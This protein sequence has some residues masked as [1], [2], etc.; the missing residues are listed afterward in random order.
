MSVSL[1]KATN[2]TNIK[3]NNRTMSEK[4]KE[5]NPHI[6]ESR[7]D[8]NKYLVQKDLKELYQEEFG[9]ALEDYNA[10]QKRNDRKIDNYYKHIESSKK[11]SLQQEMIVQVGD[12]NDFFNSADYEKGN[13]ILLEWFEKFEERNPNLK[14]YNAVIHNDEASPHLHLNF[15]P[16]ASEYKRGLEKQVSF[17]RAITQQ[18]STLDKTR[19][20]DDWREKEV[21]LLEKLLVERGIERKLVGTNEYKDVNEYKEKK[22]L[23][24]EIASLE[25]KIDKKKKEL[26]DLSEVL[27]REKLDIKIRPEI[28]TEVKQKLFGDAEITKKKT[29]NHVLTSEQL[30]EL[31][32]YVN[33]ALAVSKDYERLQSTDLVQENKGL[34][35]EIDSLRGHLGES[36]KENQNLISKNKTLKSDISD[37][38]NRIEAL[39][40]EVSSAYKGIKEYVKEH[41]K[42]VRGFKN[43]FKDV[44]D[45]VKGKSRQERDASGFTSPEGEFEKTYKREMARERNR[46]FER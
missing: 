2:K 28:K 18:D 20:F 1:K 22:D 5:R 14:V 17:D 4:E 21:L 6:N 31:T 23:E 30:K 44:V 37:L 7:S 26:I 10:K 13:E 27:P 34:H 36:Q 42:D 24:Q 40:I 25:G 9:G 32:G 8:E 16:V 35:R 46:G 15:V 45:I 12:L 38:K 43:A 11:T 41:M 39:T 3:H 19:P 29:G 33:A